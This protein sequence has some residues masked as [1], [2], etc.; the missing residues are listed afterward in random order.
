MSEE[1]KTSSI[2]VASS[3]G[4][5]EK[6]LNSWAVIDLPS[7]QK[8]MD[9]KGLE[10]QAS[11][12]ES[13]LSRK[14]LATKTKAFKKLPEEEKLEQINQLVKSYQ[15]EVD[16]L[17]K[18]NKT[19]ENVFFHIY[20]ALA[21]APDPKRLL[22]ISLEAVLSIKDVEKL[23]AEKADLEEK[24]L[25]YADYEQLKSKIAKSEEEMAT[26]VEKQLQAKDSE[27]QA[28]LEEKELNWRKKE[29]ELGDTLGKLKKEVEELKVNDEIMRLRLK[30]HA[31]TLNTEEDGDSDTL[32]DGPDLKERAAG[33]VE[34]QMLSRD[35]ETAKLRV[36]ELERRNEE[37]RREISSARSDVE[38]D[39]LRQM[40]NKRISELESENALLV[41]RLEHERKNADKLKSEIQSKIEASQREVARLNSE[42]G[43]LRQR[44]NE[45]QDYDE[46][47][48]ELEVLRQ[49]ELGDEDEL[50]Q[51]DSA[52]VQRNKKLNS[53]LIEYRSKNEE[54]TKKCE[55]L[56]KQLSELTKQLERLSEM[57]SKLENDLM[58]L[59]NGSS[60]N[61]K[62]ETMSMISSVAPSVAGGSM[63]GAP[64]RGGRLSPA[65]SIA[66]GFEPGAS[67]QQNNSILPIITQQR[68]RFRMRNKELEEE[69]KKQFSKI[70]ELRR[71]INALKNDNKGLY[72]RIRFLQFHQDAK[73]TQTAAASSR[74]LESKY[75]DSY[76]QELHPIEQFRIMESQRISS[77][78]SPFERIFIQVTRFVLSTK[79]SRL[80][81]VAY[82]FGLHILVMMLMVY[83]LGSTT[84]GS[85]GP[86][87]S[88]TSS[89]GGV[90][91]GV[92]GGVKSPR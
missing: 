86:G 85:S 46:I 54:L 70:V 45:T 89:T 41:A 13:L 21:E 20:R 83:V 22:Q 11:Q 53:E 7:L 60:S 2:D 50:P 90:A 64:S 42:A 34:L 39:K 61:D 79:Y 68:D 82:C 31:H 25:G 43:Q 6:A 26:A 72:E 36:M 5:F 15:N 51:L 57:N 3:A 18:K 9:A 37:L 33:T 78:M 49:I 52:I 67:A 81:F 32:A 35:A 66:G 88:M 19:V 92:A 71:E 28:L 69:T 16:S 44:V 62:W 63:I 73:H 4:V 14:D 76:E 48:K 87:I 56:E 84:A 65:S 77:R 80:M 24:L 1:D 17:T 55:T 29:L 8:E 91:G 12:K 27:W 30:S 40:N 58:N 74:D 23:K 47:K 59:E 10:I 75:K 38:I